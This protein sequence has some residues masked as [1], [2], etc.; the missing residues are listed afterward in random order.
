MLF[1]SLGLLFPKAGIFAWSLLC[2]STIALI[3]CGAFL[4]LIPKYGVYFLFVCGLLCMS[5]VYNYMRMVQ[6]D[7]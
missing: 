1:R 3:L 2:F 5:T 7:G 4:V 6:G